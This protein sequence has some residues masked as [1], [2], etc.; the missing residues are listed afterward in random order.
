MAVSPFFYHRS[1]GRTEPLISLNSPAAVDQTASSTALAVTS[2]IA[3]KTAEVK[4]KITP[5]MDPAAL[6]R[7]IGQKS[8]KMQALLGD[9]QKVE[10]L[11][12]GLVDLEDDGSVNW[13]Y[14]QNESSG[15][16][17]KA[18]N[19]FIDPH[20][21]VRSLGLDIRR[22][23]SSLGKASEVMA[24]LGS[25]GQVFVYRSTAKFDPNYDKFQTACMIAV[26]G[27]TSSGVSFRLI[28]S[29][30]GMGSFTK[31]LDAE[32]NT[33]VTKFTPS[34]GFDWRDRPVWEMFLGPVSPV[35]SDDPGRLNSY[36]SDWWTK[37]P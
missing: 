5:F 1:S 36:P 24:E 32:T 23:W 15:R 28:I 16:T 21:R 14:E 4:P 34:R 2:S 7:L 30:V 27:Q 20:R 13:V 29:G 17:M 33:F 22:V 3:D 19:A 11:P 8:S 37:F 31:R 18:L 6:L 10:N 12:L 35:G 26:V 9:P 25:T